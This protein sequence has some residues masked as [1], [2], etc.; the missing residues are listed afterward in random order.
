MK[1]LNFAVKMKID[2]FYKSQQQ[3][4]LSISAA[5]EHLGFICV[6]KFTSDDVTRDD[7]FTPFTSHGPLR[8]EDCIACALSVLFSIRT[9]I[10]A[11]HIDIAE[12]DSSPMGAILSALANSAKNSRNRTH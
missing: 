5:D 11:N 7:T 2:I 3:E 8:D 9:S 4:I 1:T 6:N 10:N 12:A